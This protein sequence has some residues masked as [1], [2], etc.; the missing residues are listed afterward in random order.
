MRHDV[1][2]LHLLWENELGLTGFGR[3]ACVIRA[4]FRPGA[5]VL[6]SQ[7]HPVLQC[8][9]IVLGFTIQVPVALVIAGGAVF[10]PSSPAWCG[11]ARAVEFTADP[12]MLHLG[13]L[14]KWPDPIAQTNVQL[15]CVHIPS[16][17]VLLTLLQ[18]HAT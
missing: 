18:T 15:S 17:E 14:A 10:K 3:S 11:G 1:I 12:S 7:A 16:Q 13:E 6:P 4:F 8:T 9:R 2:S 5:F